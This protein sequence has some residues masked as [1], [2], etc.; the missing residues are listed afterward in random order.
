MG[1]WTV[2]FTVRPG[3]DAGVDADVEANEKCC[4]AP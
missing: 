2:G 1:V 4:N 3:I